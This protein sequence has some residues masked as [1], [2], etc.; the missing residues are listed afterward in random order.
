ML[1]ILSTP[2]AGAD[3]TGPVITQA[4]PVDSFPVTG[5]KAAEPVSLEVATPAVDPAVQ[6]LLNS[7]LVVSRVELSGVHA[8]PFEQVASFFTAF[9]NKDTTVAEML[10]AANRV[11]QL[12]RDQGY[13]LSFAIVPAQ[14]FADNVV[15]ITVVEGYVNKVRIEGNAGYSKNRLKAI[16][17][18][19]ETERP[20]TQKAFERIIGVFN[21]QPGVQ[22]VAS[23]APPTTEDGGAEM[24]L[25]VKRQPIT[26]GLGID[27]LQSGIRALTTVSTNALTPLGEQ[28]SA[29]VLQP[30]GALKESYYAVN[31]TQPVGKNGMLLKVN[32]SDYKAEPTNQTL[33]AQQFQTQYQ[34]KITRLGATLSYPLIL[35]NTRTLTLTGGLYAAESKQVFERSVPA[36]QMSVELSTKVRAVSAEL[37]YADVS[38]NSENQQLTRQISVGVFR[39]INGLGAASVNSNA[40]LTFT[41]AT[42]QLSLAKQLS[43]GFGIAFAARGQYSADIL[44]ST[45][46]IGYGGRLFGLG[47]PLGEIAGDS[48]IGASLEL[49]RLFPVNTKYLKQLQPYLLVDRAKVYANATTLIHDSLAS[50]ALGIRLSDNRHYNL[51]FSVAKPIADKPANSASMAPRVNVAYSYQLN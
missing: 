36:L 37:A 8:L 34:T 35:E 30:G 17:S 21:L 28:L 47:Y 6:N 7:H 42:L 20:L 51:D 38:K 19:L 5:G 44:P 23:V 18:Q 33:A 48:G 9:V 2:I 50:V 32:G 16:A 3:T 13:P 46:Q 15:K 4:N 45:E 1:L 10:T 39:G 12:Y 26:V 40:D 24:L 41:R 29:S 25:N 31:Y 49:N 27:S 14:T 43:Y 22:V 11:T